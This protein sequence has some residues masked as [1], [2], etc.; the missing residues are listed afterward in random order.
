[1]LNKIIIVILIMTVVI[2]LIA[3]NEWSPTLVSSLLTLNNKQD[4][5]LIQNK[6][7]DIKKEIPKHQKPIHP[8]PQE[9]AVELAQ[10]QFSQSPYLEM[11]IVTKQLRNCGL[12]SYLN[13]SSNIPSIKREQLILDYQVYCKKITSQYLTISEAFKARKTELIVMNLAMD[14]DFSEIIQQAMAF[15]FFDEEQK[16]KFFEKSIKTY[17]NSHNGLI[18]SMLPD[19]SRSSDTRIYV[20]ELSNILGTINQKYTM[21]IAEQALTLLSCQYSQGLSCMSTSNFMIKQCLADDKAC[22][23]DVEKWFKSNHTDAHNRDIDILVNLFS[24]Y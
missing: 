4:K 2:L 10:K 22:G 7:I 9:V 6:Q 12:Y 8:I 15:E 11:L 24:S 23:L 1:M 20:N 18:I 3:R 21:K 13:L 17:I 14:S 5:T 19:M 16:I